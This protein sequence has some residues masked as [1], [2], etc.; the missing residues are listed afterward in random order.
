MQIKLITDYAL[1][2]LIYLSIEK[3]VA[4]SKEISE[5]LDIPQKNVLSIGKRLSAASY[6]KI[7]N[8]PYGGY[9]INKQPEDVVLLDAISIFEDTK[10]NCRPEGEKENQMIPDTAVNCLYSELQGMIET[11]LKSETLADVIPSS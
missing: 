10:I 6:V 7:I 9:K 4:N 1:R 5:R 8:G 2:M 3:N 11:K